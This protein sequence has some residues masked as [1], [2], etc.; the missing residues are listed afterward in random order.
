MD[1]AG[2]RI[3]GAVTWGPGARPQGDVDAA[4]PFRAQSL[5]GA[6][7]MVDGRRSRVIRVGP[8]SRFPDIYLEPGEIPGTSDRAGRG[9]AAAPGAVAALAGG[10]AS[11]AL[12]ENRP[13]ESASTAAERGVATRRGATDGA[14]GP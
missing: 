10:E 2:L 14:V 8:I 9:L 3:I 1:G 5:E 12:V 13:R 4:A 11:G 6:V 7:V